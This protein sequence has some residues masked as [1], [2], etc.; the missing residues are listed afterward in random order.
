VNRLAVAAVG[1]FA[2]AAA[3]TTPPPTGSVPPA[4][5]DTA[6]ELNAWMD[7]HQVTDLAGRTVTINDDTVRPPAG[8]TLRNGRLVRTVD[9]LN[10]SF[11]HV[12]VTGADV[13]LSGLVIVGDAVL[14]PGQP[15]MRFDPAREGQ[16]GIHLAGAVRTTLR[17]I[18]IGLVWGDGILMRDDV[19][20]L[21][22]EGIIVDLAGRAGIAAID[23]E[24]V[25]IDNAHL[26]RSGIWLINLEPH[27]ANR[28][29]RDFTVTRLTTTRGSRSSRWL[30]AAGPT[31]DSQPFDC[32]MRATI[33]RATG[34][35]QVGRAFAPRLHNCLPP[36][37]I[38]LTGTY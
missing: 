34:L 38:T 12:E 28:T 21:D 11:R 27:G 29:V 30:N 31:L 15:F 25:R 26:D 24:R 10:K 8:S 3:C 1:V 18:N 37:A 36:G 7:D 33:D 9:S 14:A 6:S 32:G 22:A 4:S 23:A 17:A 35:A 19:R 20:D 16:H 5:V 2:V 13:T